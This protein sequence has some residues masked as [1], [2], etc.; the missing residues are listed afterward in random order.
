[1]KSQGSKVQKVTAKVRSP[2]NRELRPLS[3]G[4]ERRVF[5]YALAAGAGMSL[6]SV[7][8]AEIVYTQVYHAISGGRYGGIIDIDLNHDGAID[9]SLYS[10]ISGSAG[11]SSAWFRP[12][13]GGNKVIATPV[14]RS[15]SQVV[16]AA[17]P[18]RSGA[19]IGPG[20]K[21]LAGNVY[22]GWGYACFR[23]GPWAN[24]TGRYLGLEFQKDGKATSGGRGSHCRRS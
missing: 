12:A 24:K 17:V 11:I 3:S 2:R 20:E 7:A 16:P 4:L 10:Y 8:A 22:M 1:M 6:T 19:S 21:F 13:N 14:I 9:F 5:A 18:L 23:V 15:F